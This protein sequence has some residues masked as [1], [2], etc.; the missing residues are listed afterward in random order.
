[1]HLSHQYLFSFYCTLH[2]S[3]KCKWT[4]LNNQDL[5]PGSYPLLRKDIDR[6]WS[7]TWWIFECKCNAGFHPAIFTLTTSCASMPKCTK[8]VLFDCKNWVYCTW[9]REAML[10]TC[11]HSQLIVAQHP[12]SFPMLRWK[13][14]CGGW[15]IP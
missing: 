2:G 10:L 3:R 5:I 4:Q 9:I 11:T 13:P 1:M 14:I 7:D 12:N 15:C 8:R 6:V